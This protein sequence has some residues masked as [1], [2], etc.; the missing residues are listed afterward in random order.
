[1]GGR[2]ASRGDGSAPLGAAP[3]PHLG[4]GRGTC[5]QKAEG[6]PP[7]SYTRRVPSGTLEISSNSPDV[8]F[9]C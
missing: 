1:M 2:L 7:L 5:E 8:Q 9:Q 6:R 4:R 3:G